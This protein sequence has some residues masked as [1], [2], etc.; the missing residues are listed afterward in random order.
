MKVHI[1]TNRLVLREL[2]ESDVEGM[3]LLDSDPEVHK[4]LGNQPIQNRAQA[5]E[6]I[7]YVR[8]QYEANG[9][10]RLAVLDKATGDFIGWSGL[11]LEK[12]VHPDFEYYDLGYRF[13]REYWGKGIATETAIAS[14][15]FGFNQHQFPKIC[16]G[17]DI[18]NVASNRILQK[19]GLQIGKPFEY[20]G[21]PHNWYEISRDKWL[22]SQ[23]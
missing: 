22:A 10:G 17:A 19:V 20:L 5:L 7:R 23:K 4:Y 11:K 12:E 1:E 16:A 3:F 14:L 13:R 15:E 9:L 21:V 8:D 2:R 18:D 6:N